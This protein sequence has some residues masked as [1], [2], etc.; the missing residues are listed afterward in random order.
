ASDDEPRLSG[1]PDLVVRGLGTG[2]AAALLESSVTGVLDPGVR[3]R[4]LAESHG[5]PLALL[6][7]PRGLAP[8]DLA[9]GG[10]TGHS[11][12]PL[13]Q[14]RDRVRFRHPLVR[15]AVYRS[16]APA[17]R[18]EVHRALVDVADPEVDPDRR[19]WH[20][21]RAAVGPD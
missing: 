4:I 20:R 18:R 1:L 16:A 15:S 5:N 14:R 11:A 12:T 9:F 8:A 7:L 17:E 3:D 10:E 2:D 6:E 19:A 13:V 21:S